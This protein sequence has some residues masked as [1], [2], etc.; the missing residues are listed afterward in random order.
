MT[1]Q[2]LHARLR[3]TKGWYLVTG[4]VRV[5]EVTEVALRELVRAP[6]L[7]GGRFVRLP[8]G[9]YLELEERIRRVMA[10]LATATHDRRA[11]GQAL[12]GHPGAVSTLKELV[13]PE[14]GVD[15]DEEARGW[16]A[17]VEQLSSRVFAVPEALRA[18]LRPYQVDGFVWLCRLA[19]LGLGA[20]LADDMG[21]GKTVQIIAHLLTR[22]E[23]GPALV[24]APTSVCSNWVREL[25]RF[26][27][28][29]DPVE[30]AGKD[31]EARLANLRGES[32]VI[33]SYALLQQDQAQLAGIAWGTA[34][35]DEA[36]FIKNAK[37][38]RAQAAFRLNARQRIAATGTPVENHFGDLFSIFRFLNPGLLGEWAEFN[39]TFIEP[40]E[41][42]GL[43]EPQVTLRGLVRPYV[44]R[45][46]KASVLTELPPLTEVQ[47]DVALSR[48][49][50]L[51]YATLR[52]QI[53]DKLFTA[54]GKRENKIQVLAEITRL[55]RFC[56]HPRLVFPDAPQE[57]S[58]VR[59]FL[60]LAT[61]LHENG[62]RALVFSQYVDFLSIVREELEELAIPYEYLDGSTPAPARQARVDAFQH[63]SATLFLISLKAGG[64]GLNLTGADTV[65]H[66]D[67]WWNPAV[68]AQATDR[69]HRI[70][71]ERPVTVYRLITRDTI[72]EKIVELHAQKQRLADAL[73]EGTEV[74]ATLTAA[75]LT[76]LI[77]GETRSDAFE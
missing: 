3:V 41:R 26:A 22:V 37:A 15:V 58:K 25:R 64:F 54:H 68:E 1:S 53:H 27:P 67:P 7:A 30:Y 35:L 4:G 2:S 42:G 5:D 70:G 24:V 32:V 62:R 72:E 57:S 56:C 33:T 12:R 48:D 28:A 52:R 14:S 66:L 10:A 46:T 76:A 6:T 17:R 34:V 31:R 50:A 60:D 51:R 61:E 39:R 77:G 23:H 55:R 8:S 59:T 65:I 49:E 29:L 74:P 11:P 43:A 38:R 75:E 36:Q 16:L 69:S 19:E 73:L 63:G 71:Q 9:D 40:V 13:T 21:L 20:C 45:R 44:L 47:H 18:E